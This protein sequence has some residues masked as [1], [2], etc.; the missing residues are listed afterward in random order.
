M[1]PYHYIYNM[2]SVM[3]KYWPLLTLAMMMAV[4][5]HFL[6]FAVVFGFGRMLMIQGFSVAEEL[7]HVSSDFRREPAVSTAYMKNAFTPICIHNLPSNQ[8]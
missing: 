5:R 2:W 4:L 6:R 7:I 1:I 8:N 3:V